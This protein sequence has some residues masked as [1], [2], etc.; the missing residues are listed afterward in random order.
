M[1]DDLRATAVLTILP[2]RWLG[3]TYRFFE[4]IGSTND[5]LKEA[6]SDPLLP[7]GTVFLTDYQSQ[8]RGRLQRRWLAPPGSSLLLSLLFRPEWPPE[9]AQWLTMLASVAAAEAVE[10]A[11]SLTVGVKWPNDLVVS[12]AGVW[13][14]FGG[15]LLE[16]EMGENGRFASII[17]GIG[18]NVNI[19]VEQM[20]ETAV[21]ATSLLVAA[22]KRISRLDLLVEFLQRLEMGYEQ[23]EQG[24]S[25]QPAWQRRMVTIGQHVQVR[26]GRAGQPIQG[27]AEGCDEWGRLLVR[28]EAGDL[29]TIAAGDITLR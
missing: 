2:T 1:M 15:L 5:A 23:A 13:H 7:A 18:I 20:P 9:Q 10:T 17:L 26:N 22:G 25:P 11:T 29:H 24:R 14:K 19:P 4:Q 21:P 12:L 28:D 27:L 6:A 8:G 16:G 3:Q